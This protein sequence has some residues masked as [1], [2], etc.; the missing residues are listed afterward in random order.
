MTRILFWL[1]AWV[2][3]GDLLLVF[4]LIVLAYG[5]FL[6]GRWYQRREHER[7]LD[8]QLEAWLRGQQPNNEL[9]RVPF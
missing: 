1:A 4:G 3:F 7:E 6:A 5:I 8:G 9:D 2:A